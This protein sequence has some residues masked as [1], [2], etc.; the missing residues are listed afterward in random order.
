MCTSKNVFLAE[1]QK[2]ALS[3]LILQTN[4]HGKATRNT[5]SN[6]CTSIGGNGRLNFEVY[7]I[8]VILTNDLLLSIY[9]KA[10]QMQLE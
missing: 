6:S 1:F 10:I 4:K 9:I 8:S 7:T 5:I 2:L 3:L